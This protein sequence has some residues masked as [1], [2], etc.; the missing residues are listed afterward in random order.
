MICYE[1]LCA[2]KQYWLDI[3]QALNI[4]EKYNF[5]FK[6]S[7]KDISLEIDQGIAKKASALYAD[8][9]M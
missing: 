2:S 8:L 1:K 5:Q 7:R 4:N 6:E 3:L 9:S